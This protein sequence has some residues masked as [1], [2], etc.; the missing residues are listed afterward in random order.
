MEKVKPFT[1]DGA[2]AKSGLN[3]HTPKAVAGMTPTQ[4]AKMVQVTSTTSGGE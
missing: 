1:V 3:S 4:V 2:I